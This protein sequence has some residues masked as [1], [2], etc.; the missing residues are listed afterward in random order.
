MIDEREFEALLEGLQ[1]EI[2]DLPASNTKS[3][4]EAI[5]DAL[6]GIFEE[7]ALLDVSTERE[8]NKI[9]KSLLADRLSYEDKQYIRLKYDIEV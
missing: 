7:V 9:L 2:D 8:E 6:Y 4:L 5:H 1:G 3:N